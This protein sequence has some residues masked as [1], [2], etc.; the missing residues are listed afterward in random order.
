MAVLLRRDGIY[1]FV[2]L[3]NPP[4]NAIN[5]ETRKGLLEA[6]DWAERQGLE[7]VILSGAGSCFA[8]GA[9]AKEFDRAPQAPHLPDV[10]NYIESSTVPWIAALHG[11]V[12]GGGAELALACRCRVARSDASIGFPEVILGLVPGLAA[13]KDCHV[14]LDL[15]K[16]S[17]SCQQA[18]PL[19]AGKLKRLALSKKLMMIRWVLRQ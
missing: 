10:L 8:A 17:G 12:L 11:A 2:V 9:D 19:M 4:V 13:H 1:G 5:F 18:K 15:M 16:R 14:L 3:N 6:V 7:R